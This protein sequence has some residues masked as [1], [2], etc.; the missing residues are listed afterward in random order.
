[1]R[2][3]KLVIILFLVICAP[4]QLSATNVGTIYSNLMQETEHETYD[5]SGYTVRFINHQSGQVEIYFTAHEG[6]CS[7]EGEKA[8]E[9]RYVAKNG[10]LSFSVPFQ[11][12]EG[13][14]YYRFK[15]M[16]MKDRI[17][18]K[19]QIEYPASPKYNMIETLKLRKTTERQLFPSH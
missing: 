13:R 4:I 2:S 18:G 3:A 7:I 9:V 10:S 12:S 14:A 17:E 8:E 11:S 5:C 19:L 15:G 16:V 1:M 6:N